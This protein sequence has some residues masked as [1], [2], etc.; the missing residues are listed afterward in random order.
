MDKMRVVLLV[1]ILLPTIHSCKPK[2]KSQPKEQSFSRI[3]KDGS[4][5][6]I[7]NNGDTLIPLD[8]YEFLNPIDAE[9]MILAHSSG[10]SGYI[11]IH[12]DTLI[13]F[14]Y[15]DL[16][17]FSNGLAPA[18][19][20]G[21]W[22]FLDRKGNIIISHKFDNESYFYKCGLAS[23]KVNG[24]WGFIDRLGNT[25]VPIIHD[26]AQ[27][28][29]IDSLVCLR[30]GQKLAFFSCN[31]EQL[32]DF[33]YDAI[34]GGLHNQHNYTYFK[35]GPCLVSIEGKLGYIDENFEPILPFGKFEKYNAFDGSKR[36][37]V[38][39]S[40]KFGLIDQE[41]QFILMPEY[42]SIESFP[43]P[44]GRYKLKFDGLYGIM[45]ATADQILPITYRSIAP[46]YFKN[47]SITIGTLILKDDN[48]KFGVTDY[49][50]IP[51]IPMTYDSIDK[52]EE[53]NG[54]SYAIVSRD[55]KYGVI[56]SKNRVVLPIENDFIYS[57]RWME[58]LIVE[59]QGSF[60][61][62][63]KGGKEVLLPQ[64]D[65]LRPCYYDKNNRFIAGQQ[66]KL[67]LI[68]KEGKTIIPI[69]YDYISNWVEYGPNEHFV[70]KDGKHGLIDRDGK[71][72]VPPEYDQ[73]I[74]N[75]PTL[76]KVERDGLF[77]TIDRKNNI[78]HP[79]KYEK[80][81]WEWPYITGHP[82]DTIFVKYNGAY[83]A[84][85]TQANIIDMEISEKF[86]EEKFR[87][88]SN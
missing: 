44:P 78:V 26:G 77:G 79:I 42:D 32:T 24:K 43:Y 25:V 88:L 82:L 67:G 81:Y 13:N 86:I 38:K 1:I 50:G 63:T 85:D 41:G 45:D 57:D 70:V 4:W 72:T 17:V 37:I 14:I 51:L 16:G 74:Y 6:Y 19:K 83:F 7:D 64:Y 54:R 76:I 59:K 84:T 73:I 52:F 35:N 65:Y 33:Q 5:G 36:A 9:G 29:K 2:A 56:D 49:N 34:I 31:G 21:K 10:K 60:G 39:T 55:E 53:V 15:E 80:M 48:G 71:T 75:N 3:H 87:Y 23:A 62:Y 66:G 12:Q 27:Y 46:N 47:D 69:E 28:T 30:M 11:N 68:T 8:K 20:N 22:G 18:K 58:Y 40:S 61:L